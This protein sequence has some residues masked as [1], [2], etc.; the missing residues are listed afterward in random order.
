MRH[1]RSAF[2]RACPFVAS[3]TIISLLSLLLALGPQAVAETV[4]TNDAVLLGFELGMGRS[5]DIEL[6]Y[7]IGPP[8]SLPPAQKAWVE[9]IFR[10]LV[11]QT[12]RRDIRYLLR[13]LDSDIVNAFS[14]PGGFVYLTT[15]LLEHLGNDSDALANVIGHE[16]AH[17]E[18][19]HA[20]NQ[21]LRSL[22]VGFWVSLGADLSQQGDIWERAEQVGVEVVLLGWGRQQEL[23]A[24][25]L[26]QRLAAAA[27]YDPRG[28]VAFFDMIELVEKLRA[29]EWE[30]VQT[31]PLLPERK[32]RARLLAERLSVT[33]RKRPKPKPPDD[34]P[35]LGTI[36][37]RLT[38]ELQL[39][40]A[41]PVST[42]P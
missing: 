24:D 31:H 20:L 3:A 16:L 35:D 25:A 4:S 28:L 23:E 27:G 39:I 8:T 10:D 19:Q 34:L 17:V 18:L 41:D 2:H 12:S 29:D 9:A 15:A 14:A 11:A 38:L 21:V 26:G 1:V 6:T 22:E 13:V 30:N 42:Q 32:Q 40:E 7:L 36:I 33:E 5:V 37:E